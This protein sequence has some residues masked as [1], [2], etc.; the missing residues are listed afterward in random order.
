[1]GST[2]HHIKLF[3]VHDSVNKNALLTGFSF[4]HFLFGVYAAILMKYFKQSNLRIIVVVS[5]IH[6]LY[7][8]KDYHLAYNTDMLEINGWNDNSFANSIADQLCATIGIFVVLWAHNKSMNKHLLGISFVYISIV[9]L[10]WYL[11]IHKLVN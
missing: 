10:F 2:A 9:A 7:E 5:I 1:M 6:L 8:V 4:I 11:C 3:A